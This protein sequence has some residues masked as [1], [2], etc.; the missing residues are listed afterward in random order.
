MVSGMDEHARVRACLL[1]AGL[2]RLP[3]GDSDDLGPFGLDSLVAVL[4]VIELEKEF[5]VTIPSRAL[6]PHV[7]DNVSQLATL[8]PR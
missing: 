2:Q 7:F 4:T 3:P 5:G 1:R 8:I 6:T